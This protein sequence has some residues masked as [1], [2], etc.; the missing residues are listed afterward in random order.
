VTGNCHNRATVFEDAQYC[1]LFLQSVQELRESW[2][3][4][5]IAYVLMPDHCHLIVNPRDGR[6][7]DLAGAM[8][9]L[10]ARRMINVSAP[11]TFLLE[12]PAPDGATHQ[13]WQRALKLFR[14]GVIG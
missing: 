6:I 5:L 2:P 7:T 10:S 3:F 9:G 14:Y 1:L 8:K 13:V 12:K 11:G 4:K